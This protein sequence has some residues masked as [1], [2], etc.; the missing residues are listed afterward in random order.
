[1]ADKLTVKKFPSDKKVE[2]RGPS[3]L[4][5][6]FLFNAHYVLLRVFINPSPSVDDI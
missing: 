2:S 5:A 3:A 4:A 1:M 6:S